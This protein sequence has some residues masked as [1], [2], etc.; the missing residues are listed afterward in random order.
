MFD[1]FSQARMASLLQVWFTA[2]N[3]YRKQKF[4][5]QI[6]KT[7]LGETSKSRHHITCFRGWSANKILKY[8]IGGKFS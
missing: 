1:R 8:L 2:L 7:V 3:Y 6:E 4:V 5:L